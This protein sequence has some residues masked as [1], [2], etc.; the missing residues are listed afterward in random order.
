MSKF[1][2]YLEALKIKCP[3]CDAPYNFEAPPFM[4][5]NPSAIVS[6]KKCGHQFQINGKK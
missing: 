2:E 5:K 6:C 3:K 1:Q 4:D